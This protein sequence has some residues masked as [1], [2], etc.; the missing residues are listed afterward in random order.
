MDLRTRI[1]VVLSK[2]L[3][4]VFSALVSHARFVDSNFTLYTHVLV[5][6]EGI[7]FTIYT[8]SAQS[9]RCFKSNDKIQVLCSI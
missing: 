7:V 8:K 3:V 5:A 6:P 2:R 9:I 4:V 1:S